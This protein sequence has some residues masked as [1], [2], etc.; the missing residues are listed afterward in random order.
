[1]DPSERC[2]EA[3]GGRG[4]ILIVDDDDS[5]QRA[6]ARVLGS[7]GFGVELAG[8]G[9]RAV[10]RLA[11]GGFDAVLSD[12]GMPGMDGIELLRRIRAHDHELPVVLVTGAPTVE[13]AVQAIEHGVVRYLIKPV[14]PRQAVEVLD[15]AV[16]VRRLAAVRRQAAALAE[17]RASTDDAALA[18]AFAF[19]RALA[20]IALVYQPIVHWKERAVTG[21][22][23]LL[24]STEAALPH[25]ASLLAAAERLGRVHELG[26]AVRARAAG[27][28]P[29][30]D[31]FVNLHPHDLADDELYAAES[32]LSRQASRVVLEITERASLDDIPDVKER[33][34]RLRRLGF[35]IALDDLGA[36]YAGL[37]S[38]LLLSP[39]IVKIDMSLVR[40][41][42]ADATR[43]KLVS[44][45]VQLC[46]ELGTRVVVEGVETTGER[47]ALS[48]LGC[49]LM[50]GYLFARP[51]PPFPLVS[52]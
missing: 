41:V 47:D 21:H 17:R 7:A 46:R 16:R 37:N 18:L 42:D 23:A 39:D 31:L 29:A 2:V 19:D 25:A 50:Q 8:D 36:G 11:A 44:S 24:R 32:P 26:R 28:L 1:M 9:A 15:Y 43:R 14:D 13:S 3:S 6:L 4:R 40:D 45:M 52:F 12:I 22:E 51:G 27:Q 35:R 48:Q 5:V 49:D 38:F 20:A 30:G 10:E 34:S 33:L